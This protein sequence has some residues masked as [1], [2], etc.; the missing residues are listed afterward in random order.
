[1]LGFTAIFLIF[2]AYLSAIQSLLHSIDTKCRPNIVKNRFQSHFKSQR[3]MMSNIE[4]RNAQE[5]DLEDIGL[6]CS[7]AFDGPFN[8][9]QVFE[10]AK[11]EETC[12]LAIKSRYYN[13]VLKNNKHSMMVAY[14]KDTKKLAGFVEVG[15]L[16]SPVKDED[17]AVSPDVPY[18]GNVAVS[19]EYRRQSVATKLVRISCKLLEK[20]QDEYLYAA[21]DCDNSNALSLYTKLGF[22]VLLDERELI[23]RKPT[24]TPRIYMRKR[25]LINKEDPA[26]EPSTSSDIEV[27]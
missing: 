10:K 19:P 2:V 24:G 23:F 12:K 4:Y 25:V 17:E 6:L 27:S 7:V 15:Q 21:V 1:M 16:P 11:S 9:F 18:L 14:D 5:R 22:E 3:I 20:W 13:F 26:V 8:W